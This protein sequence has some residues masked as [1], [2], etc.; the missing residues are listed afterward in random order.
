[1]SSRSESR[2]LTRSGA[3]HEPRERNVE[4]VA[5]AVVRE[6]LLG[7]VEDQ[8]DVALDLRARRDVDERARLDAGDV[9]DRSGQRLLP[10]PRSSSRR[11]R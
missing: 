8:V 4:A 7:L 10:G 1:M 3:V 5:V 6:V 2:T 11:R 9:G